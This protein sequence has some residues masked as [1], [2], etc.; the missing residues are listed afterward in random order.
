MKGIQLEQLDQ[1]YCLL[2]DSLD[3]ADAYMETIEEDKVSKQRNLE[4]AAKKVKEAEES[5]GLSRKM[6]V[7]SREM[8]WAQVEEVERNEV[9]EQAKLETAEANIATAEQAFENA[10]E[11]FTNANDVLERA[12]VKKEE[13]AAELVPL[14]E[15]SFHAHDLQDKKTEES[16][17]LQNEQRTVA[18]ELANA[19]RT[20]DRSQEEVDEERKVLE[21][22]DGGNQA[23]LL[24]EIEQAEAELVAAERKVTERPSK[25]ELNRNKG[26][27]E[28][29]V[30]DARGAV[31]RKMQEHEDARNRLRRLQ[32]EQPNPLAG[33]HS[34]IKGVL[35]DIDRD[36]G[37]NQKPIGPLGQYM[38]LLKPEW[39]SILERM[40][41]NA[42]GGFLVTNK[43][44]HDRVNA[45]CRRH[46]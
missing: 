15:Q 42:L 35:S 44:D 22:A 26:A 45:I 38:H 28:I 6:T 9:A 2:A 40:F 33:Y 14:K 4:Q 19:K 18:K 37:W 36:R 12:I 29:K 11:E 30:N 32:N 10:G 39:S 5:E 21:A 27:C 16:L 43:A 17:T 7:L 3:A 41:G 46:N 24:Q 8:A 1:D 25:D 20:R 23:R 31:S 34:T 13:A